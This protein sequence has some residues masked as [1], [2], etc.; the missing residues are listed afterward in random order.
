MPQT[1]ETMLL[2]L[3]ASTKDVFETMVFTSLEAKPEIRGGVMKGPWGVLAMVAFA[4][5]RSGTVTFFSSEDTARTITS[6]MLSI[7]LAEVNGDEM[8]DAIGEI[9]NMI[10]G[11]FRTRMATHGAPWAISV[12][13]VIMG[14]QLRMKHVGEGH[15]VLCEFTMEAGNTVFLELILTDH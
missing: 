13:T 6:A 1:F 15:T 4:G 14:S 9:A 3:V 2:A 11:T 7:P 12:P 5:E 8:P 10:A